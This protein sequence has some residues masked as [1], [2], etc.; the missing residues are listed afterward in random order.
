[1]RSVS[2]R[3]CSVKRW[4]VCALVAGAAM[5]ATVAHAHLGG[6]LTL[7]EFEAPT[8][9]QVLSPSDSVTFQWFDDNED[10]TGVLDFRYHATPAPPAIVPDDKHLDGLPIGSVALT[11]ESNALAWDLADVPTG[12]WWAY[13][14]TVDEGMCT[15][16]AYLPAVF[17][18]RSEGEAMPLGGLVTSPN[19]HTTADP[20]VTFELEAVAD[21]APTVRLEAGILWP[22]KADG[23]SAEYC[24]VTQMSYAMKEVLVEM[25]PME[26]DGDRWRYAFEWDTT[27]LDPEWY[28]VEATLTTEDGQQ[29]RFYAPKLVGVEAT[30]VDPPDPAVDPDSTGPVDVPSLDVLQ[31]DFGPEPDIETDPG[32]DAAGED[33]TEAAP[34]PSGSGGGC[35]G[36]G[37][38]GTPFMVLLGLLLLAGGVRRRAL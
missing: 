14:Q 24:V 34:E 21:T 15:G 7:P 28:A 16:I 2:V 26:A 6:V 25:A 23:G 1:M 10:P 32:N 20:T 27:G 9:I 12:S 3:D 19:E 37:A 18:V 36:G 33:T 8:G 13:S 17:V 22:A 5:S 11:D 29:V 35:H 38:D 30:A 4:F 31:P